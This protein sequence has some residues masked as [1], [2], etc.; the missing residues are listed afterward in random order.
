MN[1]ELTVT[2]PGNKKVDVEFKGFT[3]KTDQPPANGGDGTAPSPFD[4]FLASIGACSGIYVLDF[5]RN[6]GISLE[7]ARVVQRME[8]NPETHMVTGVT[9]SIELPKDFPAKYRDS[10]VRAVDLCTV[11]KHIMNPPRFAIETVEAP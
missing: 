10:L 9:I 8:R 4:L 7:K 3:I 1:T 5:C 2:F 6:R 11:K